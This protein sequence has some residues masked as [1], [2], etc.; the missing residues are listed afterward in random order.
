MNLAVNAQDAMP[1]G[2]QLTLATAPALLDDA[3]VTCHP[4][5]APGEY[6]RLTVADTGV[7][8]S[9]DMLQHLFEPFF[10]TKQTGK[11]T[12]LGLSVVYG[13]VRQHAG[14]I[15]VSSEPGVGTRFDVYLPANGA[16]TTAD[17][18]R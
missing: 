4:E 3:F 5:L 14:W 15:E 6:V 8:M 16:Q 1:R 17:E 2:G 7:G 13:I 11:G 10:T 18:E 9:E 12:G